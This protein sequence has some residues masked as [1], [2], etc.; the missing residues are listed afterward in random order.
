MAILVST[1]GLC[2][3][4]QLTRHSAQRRTGHSGVVAFATWAACFGVIL[5]RLLSKLN[6]KR[7]KRADFV[8]FAMAALS[9]QSA[10]D[11]ALLWNWKC[12]CRCA[13][14]FQRLATKPH[15]YSKM[16]TM[17]IESIMEYR[18]FSAFVLRMLP[19]MILLSLLYESNKVNYCMSSDLLL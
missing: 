3:R 9:S 1:W 13:L 19:R 12:M 4:A 17:Y 6:G 5:G 2:G 15:L 7:Q 14:Q 11:S 18:V 10:P 8:R 16:A